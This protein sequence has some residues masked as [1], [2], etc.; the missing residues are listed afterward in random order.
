VAGIIA[1]ERN[2]FGATG[3]AYDTMI[4]PVQVLASHGSGSLLDVA[5]G[6]RY[7]VDNGADI[8]NLSLGGAASRIIRAALQYA[9]E[10]DVLV[11]AAAG[12]GGR[13][14]PDYPA[15]YSFELA[16]VLSVGAHDRFGTLASFSNSVGR[17][18]AVQVDAPGVGI[19]ST[20]PGNGYTTY[21]GTSMA[22]PQVAGLAALALS[23]NSTLSAS[24]LRDLIVNAARSVVA[25]SDSQGKV[26][27]AT[28]VSLAR[29]GDDISPTTEQTVPVAQQQTP[30]VYR[31]IRVGAGTHRA[32]WLLVLFYYGQGEVV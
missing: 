29:T 12:N 21:S 1:A 20:V 3:V 4:M 32:R 27:A 16:N 22:T 26:N 15:R 9:V 17:S 13:T 18:G 10:H 7:A 23:A 24:Q 30:F 28:T 8:I 14:A 6:I 5:A 25:G 31:L 11:V 2:G 19:Y